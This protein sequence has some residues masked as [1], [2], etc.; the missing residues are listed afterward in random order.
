MSDEKKEKILMRIFKMGIYSDKKAEIHMGHPVKDVK[1]CNGCGE[2]LPM[3]AQMCPKCCKF[4]L[5]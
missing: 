5:N 4:W 2:K 3:L 1:I